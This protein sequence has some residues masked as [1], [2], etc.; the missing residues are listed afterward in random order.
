[1][2]RSA[3]SDGVKRPSSASRP[4]RKGRYSEVLH[5]VFMHRIRFQ[6]LATIVVVSAIPAF[7]QAQSGKLNQYG[8]PA[9]VVPGHTT[10]AIIARDLQTRLYQFAD[11]SMMGRQVGRPGNY[12]GTAMI[13]AEVKR[14]G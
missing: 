6:S 8:N 3:D 10:A 7:T 2:V 11:D 1:M 9:R 13:A 12:K 5:G 4:S 14:L